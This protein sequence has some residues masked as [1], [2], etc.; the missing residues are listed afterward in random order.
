MSARI[1]FLI[2]GVWLLVC[3]GLAHAFLIHGGV[4]GPLLPQG[5]PTP[6]V[7]QHWVL[8]YDDEF[9]QDSTINTAKVNIGHSA[10]AT[11]TW[12]L[13]NGNGYSEPGNPQVDPNHYVDQ[14]G[15][16]VADNC[17]AQPGT[18][19][20][21]P[22][23]GIQPGVGLLVQPL[24][25][26]TVPIKPDFSNSWAQTQ[27]W[28]GVQT[29]GIFSQ[30]FGFFEVRAKYPNC[31]SNACDGLHPDIWITTNNRVIG[32]CCAEIDFGE[33]DMGPGNTTQVHCTVN[34]VFSG[35]D[36]GQDLLIPTTPVGDLSQAFHTYGV[37]WWYTGTGE[38]SYQCYFDGVP[39]GSPGA[40]THPD[41]ASGAYFLPG[42][43]Q[44]ELGPAW[45]GGAVPDAS[46]SNNDPLII[47]YARAWKYEP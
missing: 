17:N 37:Y 46:T 16:Q 13:C 38:G 43:M 30:R 8:V 1:L 3:A 18:F 29:Y 33:K 45:G 19:G 28:M 20:T 35:T 27:S 9:N 4:P 7:G 26:Y 47:Q 42:F 12:P 10:P 31:A 39:Q 23:I 21:A 34:E 14:L 36:H 40:L 5:N 24:I 41:W 22:Y 25:D 6:P 15:W 44:Q 11:M 32:N 2:I